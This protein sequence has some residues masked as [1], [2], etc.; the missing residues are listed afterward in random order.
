VICSCRL[1][2]AKSNV[3]SPTTLTHCFGIVS[4]AINRLRNEIELLD[5]YRTRLIADVVTGKLDVRDAAS[6]LPKEPES[7]PAGEHLLD[8]IDA[9]HGE[10]D[11]VGG[12]EETV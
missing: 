4:E 2:H 1:L 5:E 3:V 12:E 7:L 8:E 9:Q 6:S 11:V 10:V